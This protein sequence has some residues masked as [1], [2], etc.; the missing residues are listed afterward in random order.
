V[1][2]ATAVADGLDAPHACGAVEVEEVAGA[3]ASAVFDDKVA[4]EEDRFDLSEDTVVA[5]EVGP[6]GL[7]HSDFR[8]SEVMDD[9]HEPVRGWN[10]IGVEDGDELT[11]GEVEAGVEGTGFV[12][13]AVGAMDVLDGV[14]ESGV[15]GDDGRRDLLSFVGGVVEDLD[16]E[17]VLWVL[18]G[19]DGFD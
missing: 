19:A 2:P 18:H 6:A 4:V 9:L 11:L 7:D 16:F 3:I 10:E 12:A 5:I 1:L 15:A 17:P 8:L 13:M 14:A